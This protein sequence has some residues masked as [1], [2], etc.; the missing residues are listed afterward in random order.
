L[1][2]DIG[3]K[4]ENVMKNKTKYADVLK[5][6]ERDWRST[7]TAEIGRLMA[8]PPRK[9]KY[10]DDMGEMDGVGRVILPGEMP[11]MDALFAQLRKKRKVTLELRERSI[12]SFK[13]EAKRRKTSYQKMIREIVSSV[14]DHFD[15]PD[16][17]IRHKDRQK[18]DKTVH[19]MSH[20]KAQKAGKA[21][22]KK[23]SG[24]FR[25]LAK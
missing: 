22:V 3:E 9:I 6:T 8:R 15:R 10:T 12:E 21:V 5:E 13:R 11:E 24:A 25:A 14:A 4:A 2:Q 18:S 7:S 17:V 23:H 19:Y 20:A 1:E 16:S